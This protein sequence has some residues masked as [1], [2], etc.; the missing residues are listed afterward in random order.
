MFQL[1]GKSGSVK[2]ASWFIKENPVVIGRDLACDVTVS[3]PLASR[4][5]C[6]LRSA[7]GSLHLLDLGSSNATF[8]NG[9]QV[10]EATLRAGDEVAVGNAIFLV[11]LVHDR[12]R[13]A[14]EG[15]E[16]PTDTH[17]L[18]IGEPTYLSEHPD[19]LFAKGKPRTAEDLA[20]LF[21]IGRALAQAGS[22]HGVLTTLLQALAERFA[23]QGYW[24]VLFEPEEGTLA[25]YPREQKERF[26]ANPSLD[27]LS[28]EAI[29]GPR[30]ILLPERWRQD[31]QTGVRTSMAAPMALGRECAGALVVC[32]ETPQR[33]YDEG[34][35]EFLLAMAH[36]AAPYLQ[37]AERLE[38]L[39]R[40]NRRLMA[41]APSTGPIIGSGR[42]I[43]RV[44]ALARKCARSDLNV[45]ILGETGTGKELVA[46]MIHDLS[47]RTDKPLVVVNCAAIPDDLFESEL[48]GHE[49][50][51]FTGAHASKPG[52]FEE[53]HE[54]TLFLDEVGDTSLHNQARLLRAIE[55]GTFRRVGGTRDIHVDVRVL[56]ATNRDLRR[57][58]A[59]GRFRRDLYH[60]LNIFEI[61]LPPL[62]ER[63]N[64]IP[65]L[66]EHFLKEARA[67]HGA[68][69][70]EG[71]APDTL[72]ALQAR[73][74]MGNVRELRNAVE[75]ALVVAR[76]RFIAVEDLADSG[77]D[78]DGDGAG[79]ATREADFPTL[80]VLERAHIVQALERTR[81]NVK[82][83]A[84]LLGIGRSTL[85]RKIADY[86]IPS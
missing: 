57:E 50:G 64:D 1:A 75:R 39:E 79:D 73:S 41:G 68:T 4:R 17:S 80:E 19:N 83:A 76:G 47:D 63:R 67:R 8:V 26:A 30:G 48:F 20:A 86:G 82:Q 60:R 72:K 5:H 54:G 69:R 62:R 36:A 31:G 78:G 52:L 25:V 22:V 59:D 3:D 21:R 10:K 40:E 34:D 35:L 74:W 7:G 77:R 43:E 9:E 24:V 56:A 18:R 53:S 2:G 44:R 49:R 55:T 27:R 38:Q 45:L 16:S 6:E 28:H 81:G 70:V 14:A 51:A 12:S 33:M 11:T 58:V 23:P 61:P 84:E 85:Y 32:A 42:A 13:A 66:A 29:A 71:F 15:D 46:R 37:A 65:V